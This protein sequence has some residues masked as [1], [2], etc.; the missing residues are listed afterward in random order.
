M[1]DIQR[2]ESFSDK[3]YVQWIEISERLFMRVRELEELMMEVRSDLKTYRRV[4][5]EWRR[6]HEEWKQ[7]REAI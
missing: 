2:V 7:S 5:E 6:C 4:R 3:D 1:P